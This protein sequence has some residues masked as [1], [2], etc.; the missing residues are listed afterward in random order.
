MTTL[1]PEPQ[2][3]S[4]SESHHARQIAES[5]GSEAERYERT[6]PTYPNAMVD[7]I[8]VASPGRD[9][10]DVGIGTGISA[11]PFQQEGCQVLGVDPDERMAEYARQSGLEVEIAKFEEWDPAGRTFELFDADPALVSFFQGGA[12]GGAASYAPLTDKA[13]DGIKKTG[14]FSEP[15]Q[16]Q[17]DWERPYTRDEWLEIVPT[18]GGHSQI[19][20]EK[21][22]E[23]LSAIGDVVDAAGGHFIMG[24]ASVVVTAA[25]RCWLI[26]P[27]I[28]S[29]SATQTMGT[30]ARWK[31][32]RND[33]SG[34]GWLLSADRRLG[35]GGEPRPTANHLE[36]SVRRSWNDPVS[37][38]L[39]SES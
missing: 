21:L 3:F 35:R 23:L 20:P 1:P 24:Y 17:F 36:R 34:R 2:Q 13:I 39:L 9:V 29:R 7:A 10:L 27:H 5:F 11:R 22:A 38:A 18:F 16:W 33:G 32:R 19:P 8:L 12:P 15:E 37:G 25:S 28:T 30:P 31:E 4:P 6:R 14:M 26:P